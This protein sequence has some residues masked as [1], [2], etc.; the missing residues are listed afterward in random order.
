MLPRP[1]VNVVIYLI[2]TLRADRL[3]V[4]GYTRPTSPNIDA[5]GRDA[6]VFER[7]QAPAPWTLPSVVSILTSTF[8]CE[9]GVVSEGAKLSPAI[10][11]LAERLKSVGYHTVSL[12]VN[13]FVGPV[14]GLNR[15]YDVCRKF[16]LVVDASDVR[17]AVRARGDR[18][19]LVYVHNIEPHNPF[20]A[21]YRTIR[22]FGQVADFQVE[23]MSRL[24]SYYRRFQRLNWPENRPRRAGDNS[25][26]QQ[27]L[28]NTLHGMLREHNVL[29]DAVVRE[30]D[31][32]LGR[33]VEALQREG[34]WD[35]TL[36]ILLSDHGEE[37]AEHGAYLHSQS[38][39]QEL[40]WVPLLI[41]FP[42]NEHA[43]KR[44]SP[45]V[46]LVDV[47]PT[48]CD[49]L[50]RPDLA[51][52]ARGRS[53]LPLIRGE[54]AGEPLV[55]TTVR[56][57]VKKYF[58][59]WAETRGD[60]NLAVFTRDGRWK[61][62]WNLDLNTFELYELPT[63]PTEQHNLAG[64]N[65]QMLGAMY[66]FARPWYEACLS[67]RQQGEQVPLEQIDEQTLRNLAALGYVDLP[68]QD[69][70]QMEREVEQL[71]KTTPDKP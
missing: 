38:V 29:Y 60:R 30:A 57:N 67:A 26:R 62:I 41:R 53:L 16:P 51:R 32:R 65:P 34:M 10:R 31:E 28:L 19:L 58:T 17:E 2:D 6:V 48:I 56:E 44:I 54:E 24:L 61:G 13:D 21:E 22:M 55:L 45:V 5:L 69:A 37:L 71:E 42:G 70:E 49:Y 39:Y 3:G 47:L 59:P 20:N 35:N 27:V 1:T 50:G 11:T 43:G 36:F 14:S 12:Y 66:E 68:E 23:R 52:G 33:V 64:R 25:P 40:T 4:Y 8:L 7:A 46:S 15:G 18:P 9:H 63:D